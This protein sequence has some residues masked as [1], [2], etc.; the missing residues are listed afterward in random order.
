MA[1]FY[2]GNC[3]ITPGMAACLSWQKPFKGHGIKISVLSVGL[4]F[5]WNWTSI[6]QNT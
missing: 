6:T 5:L 4:M 1:D 3:T 2:L